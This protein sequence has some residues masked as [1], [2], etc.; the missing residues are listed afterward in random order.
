MVG[1]LAS[2][3]PPPLPLT[4]ILL[5]LPYFF[6]LQP[7]FPL[8]LFHS[9][10]PF[11]PPPSL[12]LYRFILVIL[13]PFLLLAHTPP[14]SPPLCSPLPLLSVFLFLPLSFTHSLSPPKFPSTHS[15]T[16]TPFQILSCAPCLLGQYC[17][18]IKHP[19]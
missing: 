2:L 19:E 6:I 10:S 7:S 5:Y 12:C 3:P 11:L 16:Y 14:S 8:L 13:L 9:A 18:L 17:D 1:W 4:A 15:L